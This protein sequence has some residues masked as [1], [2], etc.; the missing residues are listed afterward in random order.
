MAEQTSSAGPLWAGESGGRQFR[1]Q[2]VGGVGQ[3][4]L[5]IQQ[6]SAAQGSGWVNISPGALPASARVFLQD[7]GDLCTEALAF[8]RVGASI[9]E[10]FA[11]VEDEEPTAPD[12]DLRGIGELFAPVKAS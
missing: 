11:L 3:R 12:L 7:L 8:S 2:L 9:N 5:L 10:A 6:R 4:K 1:V